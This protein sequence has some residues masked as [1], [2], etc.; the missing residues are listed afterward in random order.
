MV[1]PGFKGLVLEQLARVL[2]DVRG[3]SMFGG[4]GIYSG[5]YFFALIDNDTL[6]FKVDD[7]T[8]ADYELRNM[9]PFR[10]Y[11]PEGEVMHYYR[12]P[13]ELLEDAEALG[14]W[15]EKAVEVA[16]RARRR[17]HSR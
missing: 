9:E 5:S 12:V 3:R 13:E 8:R 16:R 10:P 11:G 2:P 6:Y 15:A 1:S 7:L 4:V 14:P 17:P